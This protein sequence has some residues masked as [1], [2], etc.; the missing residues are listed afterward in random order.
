MPSTPPT[1]PRRGLYAITPDELDTD[2]LLERVAP[3]LDAGASVLQYRNKRADTAL[4]R[5]QARALATLCNARG[6][7]LIV[8]DDWRLA[9]E[10][11]A[12]GAHLGGDDGDVHEARRT[13]GTGRI[14]GV[15]CY[16]DL[17]RA[18][19]AV[20]A[21]ADYI[22]FGA[23]HPSSTKPNARRA[24]ITLLHD[25]A[26]LGVPRVAIGG[27]TPRNAPALVDAGVELIAVI[28]GL[29]DAPDPRAAALAYLACFEDPAA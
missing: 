21:G 10:I 15:S 14:L 12:A 5:M 6:V 28:G 3:V 29:F 20:Q 4:R 13:L 2:R 26:T 18:R 27:I 11:D 8:N 1:W 19:S 25:S 23:F 24:D 7:P 22:A 17:S 16:D 9:V